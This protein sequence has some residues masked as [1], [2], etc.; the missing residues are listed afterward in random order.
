LQV[1]VTKLVQAEGA[2]DSHEGLQGVKHS[3]SRYS[4]NVSS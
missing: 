1:S 3:P 4:M 2:V